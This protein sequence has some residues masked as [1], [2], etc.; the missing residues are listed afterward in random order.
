[1]RLLLKHVSDWL[2]AEIRSYKSKEK[3]LTIHIGQAYGVIGI[4][5]NSQSPTLTAKTRNK[6]ME[7]KIGLV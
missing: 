4:I 6:I 5:I 1:M 3:I 2:Y 7:E